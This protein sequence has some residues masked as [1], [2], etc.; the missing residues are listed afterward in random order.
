MIGEVC[1]FYGWGIDQVL[2]MPAAQFF[3]MLEA[4]R[5]LRTREMVYECY[6][7]RCSSTSDVAFKELIDFFESLYRK[8]VRPDPVEMP[9]KAL[10][11]EEG[12]NAVLHAFAL[13]R[14]INRTRKD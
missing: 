13:D 4:C 6:I 11:G 9:K 10:R 14:R 12:K 5:E 1:R 3:T 2:G 7:S 8:P